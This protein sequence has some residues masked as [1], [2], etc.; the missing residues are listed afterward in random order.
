MSNNNSSEVGET[1]LI[2]WVARILSILWA[3]WTLCVTMFIVGYSG[4]LPIIIIFMCIAALMYFGP[5]IIAGVL[6]KEALGGR[7]LLY[8]GVL[9]FITVTTFLLKDIKEYQVH[10]EN[11]EFFYVAY[12]TIVLPPLVTGYLFQVCHRRSEK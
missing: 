10:P 5:A 3:I 6:R 1:Q 4:S 9:L 8:V 7:L 12:P 11:L 2:R